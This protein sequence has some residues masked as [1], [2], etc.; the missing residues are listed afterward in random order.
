M[1]N[2]QENCLFVGTDDVCVRVHSR[3]PV[4]VRDRTLGAGPDQVWHRHSQHPRQPT[5]DAAQVTSQ[6]QGV[7]GALPHTGKVSRP[8]ACFCMW[9]RSFVGI[10][11]MLSG[12]HCN[13]HSFPWQSPT[14][15]FSSTATTHPHSVSFNGR[16]F[17]TRF[18]KIAIQASA[19]MAADKESVG[20]AR[21]HMYEFKCILPLRDSCLFCF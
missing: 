6:L 17:L 1:P 2:D 9:H 3:V 19:W 8:G 12:A 14:P 11:A 7:R 20:L 15:A 10:A 18:N 4:A 21:V 5:P 16:S 13:L